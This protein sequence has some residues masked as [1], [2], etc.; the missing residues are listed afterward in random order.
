MSLKIQQSVF[1]QITSVFLSGLLVSLAFSPISLGPVVVIFLAVLFHRW[2]HCNPRQAWWY[3]WC[4]G[5]AIFLGGVYW[6]YF[7]M[8]DYGYIPTAISALMTLLF[9]MFLG[10]FPALTGWLSLR[11]FKVN[12]AIRLW[13]VFPLFWVL[14]EWV[15]SWFFTGFP[16]LNMGVSQVEWPLMGFAPIIGE[17]GMSWLVALSAAGLVYVFDAEMKKRFMTIVAVSAFWFGG[18]MLNDIRWTEPEGKPFSV[19]LVQGNVDQVKKWDPVFREEIINSYLQQTQPYWGTDVI[20]WPETA[21]SVFYHQVPEIIDGLER[22]AQKS[23]TDMLVG[24]PY[25][26]ESTGEYYN[27]ILGLGTERGFYRKRHLVPFGE[28]IPFQKW[29]SEALNFMGL[30]MSGFSRGAASQAP[31]KA[32]GYLAGLTICYEIIFNSE[33]IQSLPEANYLVNVSNNTWFGDSSM[34]YQ[35]LQI[36]QLRARETERYVLSATNNGVSAVVDDMGHI[37]KT[38]PQFQ[39]HV[40]LAKVQ[41]RSGATPFVRWGNY[42]VLILFVFMFILLW[43][44]QRKDASNVEAAS[45]RDK[46]ISD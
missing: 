1:L 28:F 17:Y 2:Q 40:L 21:I 20:I 30:P 5:T 32:G 23:G 43:Q 3:G 37:V 19:A 4:F 42:P 12:S 38:S 46:N 24:I 8:H 18:Y 45:D 10:L 35:Q 34:P 36:S 27:G 31:L 11:Y 13:L 39:K 26:S 15:R 33:V 9:A 6:V 14:M 44:L 29:I 7:S 41:A 25:R 22:Q 16:W